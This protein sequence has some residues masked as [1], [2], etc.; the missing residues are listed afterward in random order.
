MK[1]EA[2]WACLC[3][4][5]WWRRLDRRH[6]TEMTGKKRPLLRPHR[7]FYLIPLF[8]FYFAG[9]IILTNAADS[10]HFFCGLSWG[11]ASG[12]VR[13]ILLCMLL[14]ASPHSSSNSIPSFLILNSVTIDS[15]VQ[16]GK[17]K[18]ALPKVTFV[19]EGH[20]VIANWATGTNSIMPM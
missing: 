12:N 13:H 20:H 16:A 10:N 4:W 7:F 5:R 1:I 19:L 6:P 18:S 17:T 2:V 11:D 15:T 9:L 3:A 14:S 8:L